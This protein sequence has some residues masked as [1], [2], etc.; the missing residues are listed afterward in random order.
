ML[1]KVL[2]QRFHLATHFESRDGAALSDVY[3]E[4]RAETEGNRRKRQT[5]GSED[6]VGALQVDK[7]FFPVVARGD[8]AT[9]NF[10]GSVH[11]TAR[12]VTT[13]KLADLITPGRGAACGRQ[14]RTYRCL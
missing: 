9:L 7:D 4:I 1:R 12:A 5:S 10:G 8:G 2:E 11:L 14:D 6:D 13:G 3:C